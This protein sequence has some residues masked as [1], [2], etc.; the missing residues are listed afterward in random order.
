MTLANRSKKCE[1]NRSSGLFEHLNGQKKVFAF[2]WRLNLA[3]SRFQI[4]NLQKKLLNFHHAVTS[5]NVV[6]KYATG[7][8][9]LILRKDSYHIRLY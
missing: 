1:K 5:P 7:H 3:S 9:G 8:I 2:V 4:V 6:S